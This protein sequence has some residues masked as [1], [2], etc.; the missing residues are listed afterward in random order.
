MRDEFDQNGYLHVEQFVST[1]EVKDIK[2]NVERYISDVVPSLPGSDV[3]FE[4]KDRPETLKQLERMHL[5][6]NYFQDLLNEG[7]FP[8]TASVLLDEPVKINNIVVFIKPPNTESKA[9][10]AHQDGFYFRIDPCVCVTLWIPLDDVDKENGCLRY[11]RG[12]H[13][14]GL[15]P[16]QRSNVLGFSQGI[17]DFGQEDLS[18]EVV[19]TARA[20]DLL[21]HH[22]LTIHRADE[23]RTKGR[24]RRALALT[25]DGVS[26]KKRTDE[27]KAY[28]D[29]LIDQLS[30]SDRI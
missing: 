3:Y 20:G 11:V 6:D 22:G 25:Y 5:H 8:Q 24:N 30:K 23:N 19:C 14:Q 15:R 9:T 26:A 28:Q 1:D 16:H 2:T 10:P 21:A 27:Y 13:K 7:S 12:S 4:N 29:S 18:N 17:T